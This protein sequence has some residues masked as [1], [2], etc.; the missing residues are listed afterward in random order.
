MY[1]FDHLKYFPASQE[2]KCQLAGEGVMIQQ[3]FVEKKTPADTQ[4]QDV[5]LKVKVFTELLYLKLM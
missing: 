1:A 4:A 3:L 2:A 5:K